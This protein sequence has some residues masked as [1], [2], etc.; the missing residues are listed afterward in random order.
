MLHVSKS[1]TVKASLFVAALCLASLLSVVKTATCSVSSD[2]CFFSSCTSVTAAVGV[3]STLNCHDKACTFKC[4]VKRLYLNRALI[5]LLTDAGR[6]PKKAAHMPQHP[7]L[8]LTCLIAS[9]VHTQTMTMTHP[10]VTCVCGTH[11]R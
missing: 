1:T 10:G 4:S 7:C 6:P 5:C 3:Y 11:P 2:I 8:P 9:L